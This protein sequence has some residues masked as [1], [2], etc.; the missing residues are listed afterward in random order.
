M[1]DNELLD[2]DY[3]LATLKLLINNNALLRTIIEAQI[4]IIAKLEGAEGSL[5]AKNMNEFIEENKAIA[6]KMIQESIP[7]FRFSPRDLTQA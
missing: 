1:N 6:Y 3:Q 2:R 5:V 4:S 7:E